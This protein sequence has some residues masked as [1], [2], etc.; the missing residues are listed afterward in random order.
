MARR[1]G[2]TTPINTHPSMVLGTSD[3]RLLDMTR[4]F[5]SVSRKGVAVVPYGITKVTTA[6]GELL[7]EHEDDTS[8]VLVAPWVAAGMTD[9]LQTAVNTGTGHADQLGRPVAGKPGTTSRQKTG[10]FLGFSTGLTHSLVK[11]R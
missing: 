1:F 5:A 8:R 7:Y 3:V 6:D 9:L 11:G 2:I 4:A 10:C